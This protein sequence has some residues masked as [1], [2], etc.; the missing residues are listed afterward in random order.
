MHFYYKLLQVYPAVE[1]DFIPNTLMVPVGDYLHIQWTGSD[2][3]PAGDG[4]GKQSTDRSNLLLQR[5][6][7]YPMDFDNSSVY[8]KLNRSESK[9]NR[10]ESKQLTCKKRLRFGLFRSSEEAAHNFRIFGFLSDLEYTRFIFR[11]S[12]R[13]LKWR[14][15][16]YITKVIGSVF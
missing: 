7:G 14:L 12:T 9:L 4:Q 5:E 16:V 3:T 13:A 15:Y 2:S 6:G 11:N 1:Y 8:G 10:S